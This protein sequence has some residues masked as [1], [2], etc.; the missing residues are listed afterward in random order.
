MW[1]A[2]DYPLVRDLRGTV[3][4]DSLLTRRETAEQLK[5]AAT[6]IDDLAFPRASGFT[7]FTAT[8]ALVWAATMTNEIWVVGADWR[9]DAP[10]Y[11]GE[12]PVGMRR[13]AD[14]FESERRVWLNVVAILAERGIEVRRL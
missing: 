5:I 9:A 7:V 8:A 6:L 12:C 14:R 11:D 3:V 13:G 2:M 4:Y 10:D 1:A